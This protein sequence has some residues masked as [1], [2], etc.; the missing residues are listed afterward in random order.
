MHVSEKIK[1]SCVMREMSDGAT[2]ST[3]ESRGFARIT[4]AFVGPD[5]HRSI[6]CCLGLSPVVVSRVADVVAKTDDHLVGHR[7]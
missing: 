1:D 6:S 4:P 5:L 2:S 7:N 3:V